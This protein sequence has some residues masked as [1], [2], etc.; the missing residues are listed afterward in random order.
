MPANRR[1]SF[2]PGDIVVIDDRHRGWIGSITHDTWGEVATNRLDGRAVT[3]RI[4]GHDEGV[5][6]DNVRR[7]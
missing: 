3:V 5:Y 2:E 6:T 7:A 4:D 1:H